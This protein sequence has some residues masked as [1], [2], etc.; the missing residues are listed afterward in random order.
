MGK[1]AALLL[2]LILLTASST[3]IAEPASSDVI[4]NSWESKAEMPTARTKL[5]LAAVNGKIYALGGEWND[6]TSN[7]EY[8][9]NTNAWNEKATIPT[10][11][12]MGELAVAVCQN[13]IY[14]IGGYPTSSDYIDAN[15]A[16][17]PTTDTWET[18][19]P[20]PYPRI[21]CSASTVNDKIYVIGGGWAYIDKNLQWVSI[22]HNYTD[23]YDPLSDSWSTASPPPIDVARGQSVALEDKIYVLS[24]GIIQ[25]YEPKT[26]TWLPEIKA[27]ITFDSP[28]I[29]ATTGKL[30]PK[31]IH[32]VD[33]NKH[34][35]YDPHEN[36]WSSGAPMLT[37]RRMFGLCTINDQIFAVGGSHLDGWWSRKNEVYT[38]IGY[39]IPDSSCTPSPP[40]PTQ[41]LPPEPFPT[42]LFTATIGI[43]AAVSVGLLV[44][45]KK[46][47][48]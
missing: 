28:R 34:Y 18:K 19:T 47:K 44:Y 7:E 46:R 5:S 48:R 39:G 21:G 25:V 29:T 9:P 32:I 27:N 24:N 12:S 16:Y 20:L 13:R 11:R 30:A 6:V 17:D 22:I 37:F 40:K 33:V 2:V 3:V 43:V 38:P 35:I 45:F 10:S 15:E 31:R 36:S 4:E 8:D 42:T 41:T 26:D 23:F 14:V 1:T